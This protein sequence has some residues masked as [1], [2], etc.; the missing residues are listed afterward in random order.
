MATNVKVLA[1]QVLKSTLGGA[2]SVDLGPLASSA[3][4]WI[5]KT[6]TLTNLETGP[7]VTNL[8]VSMAGGSAYH[9]APK[10]LLIPAGT[11]VVLDYDI[12]LTA[13]SSGSRDTLQFSGTFGVDTPGVSYVAMGVERDVAN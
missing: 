1:A 7:L 12:L 11:T 8:K 4:S 9:V 13:P 5:I 3:K 6:L 10:D 2:A